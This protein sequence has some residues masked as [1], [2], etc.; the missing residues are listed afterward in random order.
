MS[1]IVDFLKFLFKGK[2]V[3]GKTKRF[4]DAAISKANE[5]L[6]TNDSHLKSSSVTQLDSMLGMALNDIYG[7]N[8]V[9]ENLKKAKNRFASD[10]YEK[11]WKSHKLRNT[12]IHEPGK[13]IDSRFLDYA[14][15]DFAKVL[16]K[17]RN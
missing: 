15:R 5:A 16:N 9:S 13:T 8:T 11:A 6:R 1:I 2:T 12:I 4:I 17:L 10:L 7:K 3:S 14:I